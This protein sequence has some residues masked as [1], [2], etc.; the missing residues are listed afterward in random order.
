MPEQ[1]NIEIAHKLAEPGAAPHTTLRAELVEIAEAVVLALIAVATAWSGYQAAKWD[2]RQALLYG[3]SA[4]LRVEAAIAATEG[5]Q[6]RL[7]DVMTFNAWIQAFETK[8]LQLTDL[9]VRRFSTEYRV[10]FDAWLKTEPLTP[11]D[12]SVGRAYVPTKPDQLPGPAFMPEYHNA[13][14]EKSTELNKEATTAFTDGTDAREI[15]EIY[16]R[17][18]V[19]LATILF[20]VALAQRFKI[21]K[22][23]LGLLLVATAL[24]IYALVSMATY[25]KL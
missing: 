23:R 21:R 6:Q 11:P 13:L 2:G 19:L 8:D 15:S 10:A 4:R 3:T 25:P 20:L 22:V 7:L 18:G 17:G 14:L 1:M 24:T 16:I 12:Q 9:Y 5:G